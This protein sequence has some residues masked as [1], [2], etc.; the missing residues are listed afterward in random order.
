MV[1]DPQTLREREL[2]GKGWLVKRG[3]S[4]VLVELSKVLG[5]EGGWFGHPW[6]I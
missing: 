4:S 6:F 3:W 5:F 2:P 1:E